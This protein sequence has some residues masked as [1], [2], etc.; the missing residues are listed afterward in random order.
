MRIEKTERG[1][2]VIIHPGYKNESEDARLVQESS[3]I[4]DYDDSLDKP[5]SS[6]LW[7]GGN[8]HL[9]REEIRELIER[10]ECWLTSGRLEGPKKDEG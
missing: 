2:T 9:N 3:A 4:G 7:I 5:G 1:F 8:H 10:L 6:F